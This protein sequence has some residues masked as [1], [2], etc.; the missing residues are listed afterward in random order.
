MTRANA[1]TYAAWEARGRDR[2]RLFKDERIR[3]W[4]EAGGR[5]QLY[6]EIAAQLGVNYGW[7]QSAGEGAH[8][9]YIGDAPGL[10]EYIARLRAAIIANIRADQAQNTA[11]RRAHA[12]VLRARRREALKARWSAP[13]PA[14]VRPARATRK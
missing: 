9:P 7:A 2:L 1:D 8:Q 14:R 10:D 13:Q 5:R 3:P 11:E 12:A 6:A 4:L